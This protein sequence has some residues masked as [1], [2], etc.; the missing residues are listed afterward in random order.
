M[1][2]AP[3]A[4]SERLRLSMHHFA[5]SPTE[6]DILGC[7]DCSRLCNTFQAPAPPFDPSAGFQDF[8]IAHLRSRALKAHLRHSTTT[9]VIF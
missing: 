3:S 1:L 9:W 7:F 5:L 4:N 8:D 2:G 6:Y